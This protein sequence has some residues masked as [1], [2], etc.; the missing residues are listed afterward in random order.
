[1][2][3]RSTIILATIMAAVIT[4][5]GAPGKAEETVPSDSAVEGMVPSDTAVEGMVQSDAVVAEQENEVPVA[6]Q[7]EVVSKTS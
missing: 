5:C 7:A 1:M 2:K 6:E 3:N 4:A